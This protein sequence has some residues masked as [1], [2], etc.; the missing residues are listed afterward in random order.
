VA[1]EGADARRLDASLIAEP[2]GAVVADVS[3]ISLTLV[4]PAALKLAAPGAWLV[5]L[6]KPQ[7]EA[8]R[9]AVGKGGVVRKE[10]DRERAVAR[11]RDFVAGEAGWTVLGVIPSPIPS[12]GGN[13]EFLLAAGNSLS[14]R[15]MT[16]PDHPA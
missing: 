8:G 14:S 9:E 4:L 2:V 6:V 12:G 5:A 3:F 13:R 15:D 7:F 1:L 11:M 16:S 10:E